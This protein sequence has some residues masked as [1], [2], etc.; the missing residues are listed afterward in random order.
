VPLHMSDRT[1]TI[2]EVLGVDDVEPF[3]AWLR[4]TPDGRVDLGDCTH[5]HT[6]GLQALLRFR[7]EVSVPP[8]DPFLL[9]HVAPLLSF[10]D[11]GPM[12]AGEVS[13]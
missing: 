1:A 8:R 12:V 7:P 4:A 3:V 2:T 10:P 9:T 6:G 5:L 11:A 13:P